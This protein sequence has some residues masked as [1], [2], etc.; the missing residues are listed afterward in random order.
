MREA[1]GLVLGTAGLPCDCL[2]C[3]ALDPHKMSNKTPGSHLK[4][5]S[6]L[7]ALVQVCNPSMEAE[8]TGRPGVQC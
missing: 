3:L 6:K 8:E 1:A 5:R 4:L 7:G 2:D